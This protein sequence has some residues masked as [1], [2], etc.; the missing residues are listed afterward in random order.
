VLFGLYVRR[1]EVEQMVRLHLRTVQQMQ[2]EIDEL[3]AER[4]GLRTQLEL[5][6]MMAEMNETPEQ[7]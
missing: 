1:A 4:E 2:R 3:R 6:M 7:G 5:R